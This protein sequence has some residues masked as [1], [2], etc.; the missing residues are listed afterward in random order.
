[1]N[2]S[3]EEIA[4]VVA[5]IPHGH[6][7][8]RTTIVFQDGRR[9]TFQEAMIASLVRVHYCQDTPRDYESAFVR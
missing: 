4:E 7:H 5:E 6:R 9:F 3:N 2:V 1:M 8:L